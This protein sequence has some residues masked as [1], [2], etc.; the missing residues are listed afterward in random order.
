MFEKVKYV[1]IMIVVFIIIPG[2]A[3][4]L[5]VSYTE[6]GEIINKENDVITILDMTGNL[7]EYET[8]K[9]FE[10]GDKVK[11]TFNDNETIKKEDDMIIKIKKN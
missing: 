4:S 7:W 8:E 6:Q 11:V 10:I 1:I 3:G 2:I 5:E 9:D